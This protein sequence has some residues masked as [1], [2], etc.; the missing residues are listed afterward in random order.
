MA[1]RQRQTRHPLFARVYPRINAFAEAH[2]APAHRRELLAEA[3][4]LVVETGAGTGANFRP[5]AHPLA[6]PRPWAGSETGAG[7]KSAAGRRS[8]LRA[9]ALTAT[10]ML[11]PDIDRAAISGRSTSPIEGS[12]TPAAMGRAT[13]L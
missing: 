12:K 4:G 5:V 7:S 9:R 6:S 11:E 3:T 10:M 8:R 1:P 2:G 13:E